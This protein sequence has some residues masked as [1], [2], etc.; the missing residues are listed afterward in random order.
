M[1][2]TL[3]TFLAKIPRAGL[4]VRVGRGAPFVQ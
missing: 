2:S 4:F 3:M 1:G